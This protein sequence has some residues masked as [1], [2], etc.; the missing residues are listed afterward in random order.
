[1]NTKE[2]SFMC[3]PASSLCNLRC[4]YCFYKDVSLN[5]N[6]ESYGVMDINTA[7]TLIDKALNSEYE[8]INFCFQGG[9][10]LMAGSAYFKD[11][12]EYVDKNNKGKTV[13]YAL[14][15][16]LTLL[17]N[18]FVEVFKKN[19][20]LIGVSLDGFMDNHD[21]FRKDINDNGSYEKIMD[22][23]KWLEREEIDFNILTVFTKKLSLKPNRLFDFYLNNGFKYVQLI[24]C[25]P[26]L[27]DNPVMAKMALKPHDFLSFYKVF[28]DRWY[29]EYVKGNYISVTLF[30]DLIPMFKGITPNQCGMLGKCHLQLVVEADGSIY[31]C[32]FYVLDEYRLG[33]IKDNSLKDIVRSEN[34]DRFLRHKKKKCHECND[35]QFINICHGNCRRLSECYY[36]ESYC[37][38]R[39]FLEYAAY[40]MNEIANS[41]YR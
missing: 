33:N 26:P 3:K 37:G 36:S 18:E 30:D 9:E 13:N 27:E 12:T 41:I 2:I 40:R 21:Y 10:P 17:N 38:Y 11:F 20:F 7:H 24:P 16:N 23:I 32:D 22:N 29:E 6:E 31:P 15:T 19:H 34:A 5:R 4:T 1:M 14:Q 39:H 25:L 8:K 35:C 28:F